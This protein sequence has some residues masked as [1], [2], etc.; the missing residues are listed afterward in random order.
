MTITQT[1]SEPQRAIL[2]S[3]AAINLFMAGIGSGK[4]HLNGIKSYQLVLMFPESAGFIGANF[5]D[6]LNTST[7][8]R[9][10]E[11]W[12]SIGVTEYDKDA[13]PFGLYTIGKRPPSHFRTDTHNFKSYDNIISFINGAVIFV[14]SMDNAK[15]HEGKELSYAFLDE[16]KDTEESDVKEI[17]IGRLRKKGIYLVD[18]KL[19]TTGTINQQYNPLYITTSPAKTEWISK[20]FDLENHADEINEK[21][22]SRTEFFSKQ[23]GNKFVAISSTYHNVRNVGENYIQNILD[24]NTEERGRALVYGNPFSSLGGEYYSSFSRRQHVGHVAYD[25]EKPLH[26]SFDQNTVPYNSASIWQFQQQGSIWIC[27]CID[28]IALEN[29]RNS[30]EEVCEEFMERYPA[31]NA[32]LYFYG[33]ASGRA[34]STLSKDFKHH[35]QIVEYRLRKYLASGSNRTAFRNPP[36]IRRRD[37]INKIFEEKLPLRIV[38]DEH[39]KYSIADMLYCRQAPDGTK[40]KKIVE[41]KI[42]KERYQKYGHLSDAME[43][44]LT[45]AF[46]VYFNI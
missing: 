6:Q 12:K 35:Y 41:D 13:N 14:G 24:N 46:S 43:Y 3:T 5:Y 36:V 10:R 29:P 17:I 31:H 21:I 20:W 23:I 2:K 27:N 11:Y 39:C 18:G 44:L 4:S 7:L 22:Y 26:I 28:E 34:R 42:T 33:D 30:T 19:S 38:F 32:G 15:A 8:F 16:T 40:D 37:F 45:Q 1:I 9:V 25:P